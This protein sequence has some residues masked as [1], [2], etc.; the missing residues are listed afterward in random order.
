MQKC[1]ATPS[2]LSPRTRP[3]SADE[4]AAALG[5]MEKQQQV[6]RRF[7]EVSDPGGLGFLSEVEP[8]GRTQP[9]R[10]G[11]CARMR[12]SPLA[13]RRLGHELVR[14]IP[15]MGRLTSLD[16]QFSW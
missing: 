6:I 14:E 10:F 11:R 3:R 16:A 9:S 12:G 1:C 7:K 13:T 8:E 4:P 5:L 2:S 15:T